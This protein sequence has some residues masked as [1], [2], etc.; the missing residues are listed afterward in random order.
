MAVIKK[1][2]RYRVLTESVEQKSGGRGADGKHCK[3]YLK[4]KKEKRFLI[5][6]NVAIC[7]SRFIAVSVTDPF[8]FKEVSPILGQNILRT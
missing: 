7:R 3:G 6:I 5:Y 8:L 1:D 4:H 2:G